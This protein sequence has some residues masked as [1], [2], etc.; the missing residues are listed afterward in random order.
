VSV[1]VVET[2]PSVSVPGYESWWNV[3]VA[4]VSEM[5]AVIEARAKYETARERTR[6]Y[7]CGGER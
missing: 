2:D 4:E 6:W 3:P 7:V 1:V 5:D